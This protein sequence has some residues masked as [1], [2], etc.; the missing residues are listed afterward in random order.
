[1]LEDS[2]KNRTVWATN[3]LRGFGQKA[4]LFAF[5]AGRRSSTGEGVY[6]FTMDGTV[7]MADSLKKNKK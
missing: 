4:N 1:M 5:E 3:T 6:K 2:N 7:D